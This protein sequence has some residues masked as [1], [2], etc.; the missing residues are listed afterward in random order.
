MPPAGL[1]E[2]RKC[3]SLPSVITSSNFLNNRAGRRRAPPPQS[4]VT[5][6][7]G[8]ALSCPA[9]LNASSNSCGRRRRF[10]RR[11]AHFRYSRVRARRS[12]RDD[13]CGRSTRARRR[14]NLRPAF[15]TNTPPEILADAA[16]LDP[17]LSVWNPDDLRA[18]SPTLAS[19]L[20]RAGC[21]F[22]TA[23]EDSGCGIIGR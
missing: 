2:D 22:R 20:C 4:L 3:D 17:A 13:P 9:G 15:D 16:L 23:A 19:G 10:F 6:T 1:K 14:Q 8:F 11:V 5:A 21:G 7:T 18:E 12:Y